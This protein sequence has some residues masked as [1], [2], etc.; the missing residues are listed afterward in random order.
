MG[1]LR[2]GAALVAAAALALLAT[3]CGERAEPTGTLAV[4]YPL[5]VRGA[6]EQPLRL[7]RPPR[8][9][10]AVTPGA[11]RIMSRL[12]ASI[13]LVGPSK[14]LDSNGRI[15]IQRLRSAHPDLI[16]ASPFT[17]AVNLAQARRA[18][19]APVYFAP[20]SSLRD[21]ERAATEL[22]LLLDVP[23]SARTIVSH[24]E[25]R[26][27]EVAERLRGVRPVQVFVDTGLFTTVSPHSLIGDLA[28]RNAEAGPFPLRRLRRINPDVYLATSDSETTLHSLRADP[29]T[30]TLKAVKDG[31]VAIVPTRLLEP[32]PAIGDGLAAIAR[33]LHPNAFR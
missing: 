18:V 25:R 15:R 31:R 24:I 32:G 19:P 27:R 23:L 2:S 6:G 16:V 13:R 8:R 12:D 10:A 17:D 28:G 26:R 30:R 21:I 4:K 5:T 22:G 33:D 1:R 3:A 7:D 11:A 20:E 14:T 29:R 9:V